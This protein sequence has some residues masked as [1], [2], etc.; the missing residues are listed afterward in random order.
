MRPSLEP[1]QTASARRETASLRMTLPTWNSAVVAE[2]NSSRPIASLDSPRAS[3]V[4]VAHYE[5][6]SHSSSPA[7]SRST[8]SS[9]L[10]GARPTRRPPVSP[11]PSHREAS[12]A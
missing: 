11:S 7:S 10:Y 4:S 2:M 5:I 6:D 3:R 8:S 1:A 12:M 9:S